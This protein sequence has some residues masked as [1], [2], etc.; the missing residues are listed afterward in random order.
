VIL[1]PA[2]QYARDI[3]DEKIVA[4]RWVKYA[5]QRYFD[6]L[7]HGKGRG[8]YFDREA[9]QHRI[10]FYKFCKHSKGEWAGRI[11]EPEPWQQFV[12]W[13][14]FGW[15]NE[16]GT[17]R[18][19][20]VYEAVARKNGK[21]TDLAS[22]GLY[23]A[24]FDNE[25]GAEVYTAA[26]KYEQACIIH[27]ESTRMVKSSA[28]LRGIINVFKNTLTCEKES[29][30]FVPLGQ[31]SATSD[32]LNVHAALIDEYH[33]HP[34]EGMYDVLK[35]GM[36][37]RRQPMVYVIT[38]AGFEKGY[39]C[40]EMEQRAKRILDGSEID[41]T[42]FSLIY[43]LDDGDDWT[44]PKLWIKA[45]PNLGVSVYAKNLEDDFKEAF[46]MPSKQNNFKTKHLNI[47]TEAQ[48]RW[49]TADK[50]GLN[51]GPVDADG[52]AGRKCWG[53]LD[54]STTTD[55]S[56]WVLCFE[57][58]TKDDKYKFL[59]RIFLP[60]DDLRE[61]ELKEKIKYSVWARDGLLCLTPGNVID[62]AFIQYQI[63]EDAKK[64]D[65]Q[66]INFDPYNS[67]GLISDLMQEGMTCVEFRQGFLSMSPAVKEF[68]RKVLGGQLATGGNP[69]MNWMISC[70]ETVSDPAGNLKLVKPERGKTGRHIDGV[71]ASLMAFWR[72]V[73]AIESA[74]VYED[75]GLM[76][77]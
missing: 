10:D 31:D 44:D 18:F 53:G 41:D 15:K 14:L 75:R 35:S 52:L 51:A 38:T 9:A 2:E 64:Y 37:S 26:T 45:N 62:Y 7:K 4:C 59:Y 61:R 77:L 5:C 42:F 17:R 65:L 25:A 71:V 47:W 67:T 39:P 23:L 50:W 8:I 66:E 13:N 22:T 34:D 36:G 73:Q 49:I 3:L 63:L 56:A 55:L 24:F 60:Q 32:G 30:K 74:S 29:Q 69:I 33:A 43:T 68:E 1:H 12:Q 27:S 76:L 58:T 72:A 19:R 16:D 70:A 40:F 6:D 57:P 48:T 54:L 11:L 21:S 28:S 20:T 46:S